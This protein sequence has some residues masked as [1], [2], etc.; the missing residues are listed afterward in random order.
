MFSKRCLYKLLAGEGISRNKEGTRRKRPHTG[1]TTKGHV[2]DVEIEHIGRVAIYRRGSTYY[3]YDRDRG[4]SARRKVEGGPA[5]ARWLASRVLSAIE[6]G[7]PLPLGFTHIAIP[8]LL[9]GVVES[10]ESV[11]SLAPRTINRYWAAVSHFKRYAEEHLVTKKAD[12]VSQG[13]A[14]KFAKWLRGQ[15]RTRNG[16]GYPQGLEPGASNPGRR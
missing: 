11:Q 3:L 1:H 16:A 12:Q 7:S 5:A 14:D 8:D 10:C 9:D 2:R 15:R 4:D 6:E 13:D